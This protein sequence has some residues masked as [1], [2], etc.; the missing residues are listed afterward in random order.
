MTT[1]QKATKT[2]SLSLF[3][4]FYA[5][6]SFCSAQVATINITNIQTKVM[7][8]TGLLFGIT[9]DSRSS[10]TGNSNYGQMGY[11]N[12]NGTMIPEVDAI[13]S[14]LP[15]TTVRYPGNEIA[16]GFEWKKSIGAIGTRPNQDLLGTVGPSQPVNFGFDEFMAMCTARGISGND[17]QI[18]VPIYDESTAGLSSTQSLQAVP[19]VISNNA[20]WVEYCNSPN[21]GTNPRGGTDWAALR[22]VNGHPLPY[23]IKIWNIGNEP[24]SAGE[25]GP[26][27]ANGATYLTSVKPIIDSMLV[28][29]P[30]I[31]ITMPTTGN[32]TANTWAY[33]LINSSLAQQGKIYAL[34]QHFFGDEDPAT[35]YPG[36]NASSAFIDNLVTAAAAKGIKVF[37]GDY[38][39]N[40]PSPNPTTAQKDL[41][42]QWQGA[43]F[44]ADFLLMLSQKATIE[45]TNFW[46]YGNAYAVWHPIRKN[47]LANYTLMPGAALY[48]ILKPALLDNSVQVSTT[49]PAA[50]DGNLYAVRSNAFTSTDFTKMNVVA[51]NRDKNN[52][53]PLQVNGN[54]GYT[55]MN[56]RLITAASLVS[57]T[58][59]ETTATTDASGNYIMPP[60]SVLILEYSKTTLP[61][62]LLSFNLKMNGCA[63]FF[64]WSATN[65]Q[66]MK[67]F[68]LDVSMDNHFWKTVASI[69]SKGKTA[70]INNYQYQY[71][72]T[73]EAN[74]FF[75]LKM[76]N[77]D[78]TFRLSNIISAKCN[79]TKGFSEVIFPNPVGKA[80]VLSFSSPIENITIVNAVGKTMITK[81]GPLSN[82]SVKEFA[83]GVYYIISGGVTQKF[84]VN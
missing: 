22:A 48:K 41:A 10:L 50:S 28:V 68:E 59:T 38:A 55:L 19:N 27:A 30:T 11:H 52:T 20:D 23:N 39:H 82:I 84:I 67:R 71:T 1:K 12:A 24:W 73:S 62:E 53:V 7:N 44:E 29:D 77:L 46:T 3:F 54:V 18:M 56:A 37:I 72:F 65:E 9:F 42:M 25:F 70:G 79:S 80:G 74:R 61:L 35:A 78:N 64:N 8:N 60:M 81:K 14:N 40:I 15:Y 57:E 32:G 4:V 45:R 33:A 31:K 6:T 66:S 13:F 2:E 36:V 43:N 5:I 58:I 83:K 69:S 47:S 75:R 76:I 21:D 26:T 17:V 49:S 63:A 16:V 51:V 34:S